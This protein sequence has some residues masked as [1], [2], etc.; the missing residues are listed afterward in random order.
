MDRAL[1]TLFSPIHRAVT[2]RSLAA[3]GDGCLDVPPLRTGLS[4]STRQLHP[5]VLRKARPF[6][7]RTPSGSVRVG[8]P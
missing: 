3:T 7:F 5:G 2:K 4:R 6:L 1:L 8:Y